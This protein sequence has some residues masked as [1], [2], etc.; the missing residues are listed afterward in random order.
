MSSQPAGLLMQEGDPLTEANM[1][2]QQAKDKLLSLLGKVGL[3]DWM[4]MARLCKYGAC[5]PPAG[6]I[7]YQ[8]RNASG[9]G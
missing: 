9:R 8:Q 7:D 3:T 4:E 5:S 6:A 2:E 1:A